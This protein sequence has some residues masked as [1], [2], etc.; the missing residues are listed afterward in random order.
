MRRAGENAPARRGFEM[1]CKRTQVRPT[2]PPTN[3]AEEKSNDAN[4]NRPALL[5]RAKTK[6][7]K[8]EVA[9]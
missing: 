3:E 4:P 6:Q 8:E 7:P 1:L 9:G 5:R 2:L